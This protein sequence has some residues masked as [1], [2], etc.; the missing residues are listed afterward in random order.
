MEISSR[1]LDVESILTQRKLYRLLRSQKKN[2]HKNVQ[3][4]EALLF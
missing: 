4:H 1:S 3:W 2:N